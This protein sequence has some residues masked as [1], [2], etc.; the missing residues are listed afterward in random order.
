[1]RYA[2]RQI[3]VDL[4]WLLYQGAA[5]A[6]K[7]TR[8]GLI[9]QGKLG[10]PVAARLPMVQALHE[11]LS[12][13]VAKGNARSTFACS[14]DSIV[15]FYAY[16]DAQGT[17]ITHA[18]VTKVYLDWAATFTGRM[19]DYSA[20]S[21]ASKTAQCLAPALGMTP[22]KL[23]WKTKLR[24]PEE[25]DSKAQKQSLED[26]KAFIQ[27]MRAVTQALPLTVIR[28]PIPVQLSLPGGKVYTR[29]CGR[30]LLDS[31]PRAASVQRS[32]SRLADAMAIRDRRNAD[33]SLAS[34]SSLINLRIEAELLLFVSQTGANLSP[35][36]QTIGTKFR[37]QTKD[38]Y[39]FIRPW[40]ARA[41]HLV[42]FRVYK[43]YR[44]QFDAYLAWR[45]ALF[46]DD[47]DGLLFPFV[48]DDGGPNP[49]FLP[50]ADLDHDDEQVE[51][52]ERPFARTRWPFQCTRKLCASIGQPFIGGQILR[53]SKGVWIERRKAGMG[54]QVLGNSAE[55]F[56]RNY[57]RPS[58]Q[59][60]MVEITRFWNESERAM[61][62]VGPGLCVKTVP[63]PMSDAPVNAPE[64]DCVSGAGCLFCD[65]NRDQHSFEHAWK[66]ASL[67][68]LSL[69]QLVSE[70]TA[71]AR[72]PDHPLMVRIDRI[73]DKLAAFSA[74][75]A[76]HQQWVEEAEE[77]VQE[78]RYHPYY[79]DKFRVLKGQ[80]SC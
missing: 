24:R 73:A 64:P 68:A 47:P 40:K 18:T 34:R 62:A 14:L 32:P 57:D 59:R 28:G 65:H 56:S 6:A 4:R 15:R 48:T 60:A 5:G 16:A 46:S 31:E 45:N 52:V 2:P 29:K 75:D 17:L 70:R 77:R 55:T 67:R 51:G 78:D 44:E 22:N 10:P 63:T 76:E 20:Y 38:E 8:D 13:L 23:L 42:E 61:E 72:A 33:V 37:Y 27:T 19:S 39:L 71:E 66:L 30:K 54:S 3:P 50:P 1:M 74:I 26:T 58:P 79:T 12:A 49:R 7:S 53:A 11:Y 43:E 80:A 35:A 41:G 9:N 69:R 36:L 25:A 21:Q